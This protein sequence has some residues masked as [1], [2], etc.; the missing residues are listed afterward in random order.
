MIYR[1]YSPSLIPGAEKVLLM[2]RVPM[3][4]YTPDRDS[5]VNISDVP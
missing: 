3:T 2:E 5:R 1:Q 4:P